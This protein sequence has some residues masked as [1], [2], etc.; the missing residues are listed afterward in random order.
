MSNSKLNRVEVGKDE[1]ERSKVVA[2]PEGELEFGEV[3]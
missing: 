2:V 1:E 3:S